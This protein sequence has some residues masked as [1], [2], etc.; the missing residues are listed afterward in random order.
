MNNKT[1]TASEISTTYAMP[2][3]TGIVSA[4]RPAEV[5]PVPTTADLPMLPEFR[6]RAQAINWRAALSRAGLAGFLAVIAGVGCGTGSPLPKPSPSRV[7]GMDQA[8][9]AASQP[10][11]D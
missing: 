9:N 7:A 6:N 8:V 4:E 2:L 10:H 11:A 3:K 1:C 5:P